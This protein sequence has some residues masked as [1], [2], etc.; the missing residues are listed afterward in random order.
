MRT[1]LQQNFSKINLE[2]LYP[3]IALWV[4]NLVL[5]G[6]CIFGVTRLIASFEEYSQIQTDVTQLQAKVDLVNENR[7]IDPEELDRLTTVLSRLIPDTEDSFLVISTLER[8]SQ[9]TGFSLEKYTVN[10]P[11]STDEK[12]SLAID[13]SGDSQAFLQ[14]LSAYQ[15][16]GGRLVTNEELEFSPTNLNNVRLTLNFYHKRT[17]NNLE[18]DKKITQKDFELIK[19]IEQKMDA[20]KQ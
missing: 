9:Q 5:V 4:I 14:F 11:S 7:K 17:S 10:I 3:I 16:G 20:N 12:L 15:Y 18:G 1:N 19:S 8:L 6:C 13:G 2:P